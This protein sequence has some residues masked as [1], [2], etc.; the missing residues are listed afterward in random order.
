MMTESPISPYPLM[1]KFQAFYELFNEFTLDAT[2]LHDSFPDRDYE[3]RAVYGSLSRL[4]AFTDQISLLLNLMREDVRV[5]EEL[6]SDP[7]T[8][9]LHEQAERCFYEWLRTSRPA[10]TNVN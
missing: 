2:D 6:T 5:V 8:A 10:A 9:A 7:A 3:G 1:Q 4:M